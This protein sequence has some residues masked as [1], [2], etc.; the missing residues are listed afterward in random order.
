MSCSS[1]VRRVQLFVCMAAL[2]V[3][4][5]AQAADPLTWKFNAGDEHHYKMTQDMQMS[6]QSAGQ[7]T[8]M[9]IK[10]DLYM[11]WKVE[12]LLDDGSANLTQKIDRMKMTM[13]M[14]GQTLEFD[15][16]EPDKSQGPLANQL[17]P[18]FKA[19]TSTSFDV[20]MSPR[21]EITDVEIPKELIEAIQ[22]SPGAAT[23]GDLASEEG[24]KN[25]VQ[26]GALTLPEQLDEGKQWSNK[27]EVKNPMFGSQTVET[28]YE[29]KGSREVDG[30]TMEVF[31]PTMVVDFGENAGPVKVEV[32]GQ[33]SSGEILFN[34]NEGRL[35]KSDIK[36][37]MDLKTTIGGQSNTIKIDQN[38]QLQWVSP[39]EMKKQ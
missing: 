15:S 3:P 18:L 32:V 36:Q 12:E 29:Y 1:L 14:Q 20:T 17:A 6:I 34:R 25:L 7:Q 38:I 39:D 23:M 10:Q 8:D 33:E 9:N 37:G 16:A 21:G 22:S 27:V 19:L 2:A 31:A 35:Q 28:T 5:V 30:Q 4:A 11:T 26:Q 13:K 24:F